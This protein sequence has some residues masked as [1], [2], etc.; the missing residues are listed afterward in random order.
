MII[1]A[2]NSTLLT[3]AAFIATDKTKWGTAKK[4]YR[5]STQMATYSDE[6]TCSYWISKES[7]YS[8]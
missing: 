6:I 8:L 3:V 1:A 4:F 5:H 2:L 7:H